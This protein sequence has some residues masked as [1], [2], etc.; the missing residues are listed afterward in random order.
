MWDKGESAE[1]LFGVLT[2]VLDWTFPSVVNL[3]I[4]FLPLSL[5]VLLLGKKQD[6]QAQ[7]L[8]NY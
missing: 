8:L 4:L 2:V 6:G 7:G 1:Y 5:N 3:E